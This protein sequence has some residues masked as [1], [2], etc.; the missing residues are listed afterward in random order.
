MKTPLN[1]IYTAKKG[2]QREKSTPI[3]EKMEYTI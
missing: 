1:L 3:I 2:R